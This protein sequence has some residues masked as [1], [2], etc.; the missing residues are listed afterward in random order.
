[1]V[2]ISPQLATTISGLLGFSFSVAILSY[3]I[4]DN[5]LYR[6]ALHLFIGTSVGYAT[7][8]TY[9]QVLI[10]RLLVPLLTGRLDVMIFTAIPLILFIFLIL[11]L[12]PRL[13]ALGNITIALMLGVGSAL[14]VAGA[15]RGTLLP[16]IQAT[17]LP[18]GPDS[19]PTL[20]NNLIII[21]GTISTLLYFQFWVRRQPDSDKER[22]LP[23]RLLA[24]IGRGFLVITLGATYGGMIL[25]GIALFSER[26]V[27]LW[28]FISRFLG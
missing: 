27:F 2:D 24:G 23:L 6:I 4:G 20:L 25:S 3:L 17:W 9:N 14:A 11:K 21:V 15:L 1:M 5:L 28:D 13:S 26:V 10:P 8:I 22:V 7:L 16:Q 12:G 18:L 19:G